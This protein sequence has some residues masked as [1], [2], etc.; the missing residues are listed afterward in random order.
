VLRNYGR[1]VHGGNAEDKLNEIR[2][3]PE[4]IESLN[5]DLIMGVM[6]KA[7]EPTMTPIKTFE[8]KV[9]HFSL[10]FSNAN[11]VVKPRTPLEYVATKDSP[12]TRYDL[13]VLPVTK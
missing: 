8:K 10:Q 2:S 1:K 12:T 3:Y 5:K 11:S 7:Y 13:S 4:L 9:L 6:R